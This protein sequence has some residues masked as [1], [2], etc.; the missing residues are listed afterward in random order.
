MELEID[1]YTSH[2]KDPDK[3]IKMRRV[4]DK[5]RIVKKNHCV[6]ITDFLDPY[7]RILA[8]SI[9]NRFK[10]INYAEFGGLK[11]SE[12]RVLAIFPDYYDE[13]SVDFSISALNITDITENLNHR[14]FLGAILNLGIKRDK[15][16]DILVEEE[17]GFII[18]K[19]EI[20]DFVLF[21]LEKIGNQNIK[22]K[23]FPIYDL[24]YKEPNFK[25]TREF[26]S[27]LRL[28]LVLSTVLNISRSESSKL[29]SSN[30]VKV[31][32]E[33]INKVFKELEVGDVISV[34]GFGR[35][36]IYSLQGHSKKGKLNIVIRI[37]I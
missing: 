28:D 24:I 31:N 33:V 6:E 7:E 20:E 37:L 2:I 23:R 26:L 1:K 4:L 11:E 18:L 13:N 25:E 15:I 12:R 5:I 27:S 22:I 32:W 10:D 35:F 36:N 29:I 8:G 3:Q 9:L 17:S 34:K 19:S 16:G 14:D 30:K 21:N